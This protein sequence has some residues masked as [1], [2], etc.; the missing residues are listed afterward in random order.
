MFARHALALTVLV[1]AVWATSVHPGVVDIDTPWLVTDNPLLSTG[2]PA[3]LPAIAA[4][5]S[6]GTRMMLGA[7]YL[8]VRDASVLLDFAVFGDRWAGHHLSNL[9]WYL[10]GC[11]LW[12]WLCRRMLPDARVAWLA[13]AVY[14][15]H[16]THVESV[17]W[18]ASRKDVVSLT[19][20]LAAVAGWMRA[21]RAGR[22][23]SVVC[24]AL[25][26]WAKNTAITLP[27]ILV[28]VSLVVQRESP[29][30][31]GWWLQWIP[32][33]LV[34][35]VGLYVTLGLGDSVAM[36]APERAA[37]TWG[38]VRIEAQVIARYLWMLVAPVDLAVLYVE[39]AVDGPAWI[40][41]SLIAA[42]LAAAAAMFHRNRFVT[43]GILWFGVTLLP[44]SQIIP[45]Q[46]LMADRYLLLP[47]AGAV[48]ALAA[49]VPAS[50][51]RRPAGLAAAAVV[52]SLYAGLTVQRTTVWWDSVSLWTDLTQKQPGLDRGWAALA[53]AQAEAGDQA[54][55]EQ[56]L[57]E[58]LAVL[59]SSSLLL[60][61]RGLALMERGDPAAED[62]LRQVVE[63]APGRR[64]AANALAV[65]L[66]RQGRLDESAAIAQQL[67]IVHPLYAEGWN[68]LAAVCIDQRQLDC[69]GH[70]LSQALR[71]TPL[72]ATVW[73]NLGNVAY[74]RGELA[75]AEAGWSEALRLDPEN[76]HARRG[77]EHL[78]ER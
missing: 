58:G 29:R 15:V 62:L 49:L 30:R 76:P 3:A 61:S 45:I 77:L 43:L 48:L 70:A 7:E 23:A 72:D 33:T 57:S 78:R 56:T 12:L 73:V 10:A 69:A 52:V 55:A 37:S 65:L 11:L 63:T 25:A 68:S 59:P 60:Q 42:L 5:F 47:S 32:H 36:M 46:N 75:E 4:D 17:S 44:V 26:Y 51:L 67:V 74:L 28:L 21:D 35:L 18:L 27:A 34:A 9:L 41:L 1:L 6:I 50:W 71:L 14:A 24:F 13:A 31:L 2:S 64:K 54:A 38:L 20:Y 19:F 8:P 66:H 16:P 39:P 22:V 53:A 40:G